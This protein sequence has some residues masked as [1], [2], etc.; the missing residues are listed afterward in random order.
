MRKSIDDLCAII[1]DQLEVDPTSCALF[2]VDD[3]TKK[4]FGFS[5]ERRSERGKREADRQSFYKEKTGGVKSS[6][7][8]EG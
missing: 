3:L 4:R 5:G 2:L 6:H 7:R 1:E 8:A